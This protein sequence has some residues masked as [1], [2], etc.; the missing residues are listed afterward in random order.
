MISSTKGKPSV[1]VGRVLNV[2][3]ELLDIY[4]FAF[5]LRFFLQIHSSPRLYW[6]CLSSTFPPPAR[7]IF[8]FCIVFVFGNYHIWSS[9]KVLL[10][11][12]TELYEYC[13]K[14]GY[15]DKNLIAKWKKQGYENLCCLRCIQTRDTNFGTNCICRVPK[16]KL[17]VV[18]LTE[19]DWFLVKLST[20]I[21]LSNSQRELVINRPM[22]FRFRFP[23]CFILLLMCRQAIYTYEITQVR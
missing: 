14:E 3:V 19:F 11:L 17:E 4:C 1:E 6:R 18:S 12:L 10:C 13:I 7:S 2:P 5:P 20:S 8:L 21:I 23:L 16:S 22:C 9:F 15:A